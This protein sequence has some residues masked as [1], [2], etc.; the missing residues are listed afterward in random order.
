VLRLF[1][2]EVAKWVHLAEAMAPLVACLVLGGRLN[3][4]SG[5]SGHP[6]PRSKSRDD[7]LVVGAARPEVG[8]LR[9][10]PERQRALWLHVVASAIGAVRLVMFDASRCQGLLLLACRQ[11][12]HCSAT[13]DVR[14]SRI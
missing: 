10:W 13:G 9:R 1:A 7:A 3:L 12:K 2:L 6:S 5:R 8:R 4:S 14:H 11:S